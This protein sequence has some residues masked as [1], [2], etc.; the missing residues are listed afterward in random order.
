MNEEITKSVLNQVLEERRRQSK[1]GQLDHLPIE[2]CAKLGEKVGEVN[3]AALGSHFG[4]PYGS[5]S[6]RSTSAK[7]CYL[8]DYRKELVRFAAVAV[9]MIESFDRNEDL[10]I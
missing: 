2:Y 4:Y 9:A 7:L 1:F 8:Q 5:S 6:A 3:K 10:F